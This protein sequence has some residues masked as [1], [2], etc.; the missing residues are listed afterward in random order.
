[1]SEIKYDS[2]EGSYYIILLYFNCNV[3]FGQNMSTGTVWLKNS[4]NEIWHRWRVS[5]SYKLNKL[6]QI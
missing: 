5:F 6:M 2:V 4:K 1:M 3:K